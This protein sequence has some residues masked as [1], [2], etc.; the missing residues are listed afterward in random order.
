[1]ILTPEQAEAQLRAIIADANL[2]DPKLDTFCASLPTMRA[3]DLFSYI[4]DHTALRNALIDDDDAA[5]TDIERTKL[6]LYAAVL[7]IKDQID[8]RFPVPATGSPP[9]PR[10]P[11]STTKRRIR[12][13]FDHSEHSACG[14]VSVSVHLPLF[15]PIVEGADALA[16]R[17]RPACPIC[18]EAL[19]YVGFNLEREP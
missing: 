14:E 4:A 8:R 18:K 5:I 16:A 1:M 15:D 3:S 11:G 13:L 10:A 6:V 9:H 17:V 12:L 2:Q 19:R 7:A